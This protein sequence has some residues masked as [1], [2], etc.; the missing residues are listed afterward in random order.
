MQTKISEEELAS[1]WA[2][3]LL[4]CHLLQGFINPRKALN[5]HSRCQKIVDLVWVPAVRYKIWEIKMHILL[6]RNVQSSIL[7]NSPKLETTNMH[8][9]SW[10]VKQVE[11][12]PYS[13]PL[14]K[15]KKKK[16]IKL[17]RCATEW[18]GVK[19]LMWKK[20]SDNKCILHDLISIENAN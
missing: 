4:I 19:A 3:F 17:L 16:G 1:K 5:V 6:Y 2:K 7:C 12:S 11:V 14:S 20:K 9:N 15:K 10:R 13:I 8:T 18:M